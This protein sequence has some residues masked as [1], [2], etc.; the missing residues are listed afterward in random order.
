MKRYFLIFLALP[1]CFS[2]PDQ[3]VAQTINPKKQKQKIASLQKKLEL[4]EK[5]RAQIETEVERLA[6]EIDQAQLLLIRKQLDRCEQKKEPI[7]PSLFLEE[8]EALYRMIQA[9]SSPA[10]LEAQVELDRILRIITE[11]SDSEKTA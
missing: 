4:A 7:P 3:M 6:F 11:F 8:R 1:A 5:E 10:S 9:D 2:A